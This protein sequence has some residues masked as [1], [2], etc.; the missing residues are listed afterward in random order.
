MSE[1]QNTPDETQDTAGAAQ[2]A[3]I[4]EANGDTRRF[5]FDGHTYTIPDG[6]PSPRAMEYAARLVVD[7]EGMAMV[8]AIREILGRAQ[9]SAWCERH[10]SEQMTDFWIKL[11]E[12]VGSGN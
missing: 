5:D 1:Q 9:W 3:Q 4:A 12:A 7:E 2:Q 10:R 11:N 6:Q 8:L